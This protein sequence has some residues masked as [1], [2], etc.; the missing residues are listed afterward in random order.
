MPPDP[1]PTKPPRLRASGHASR[2]FPKL[3]EVA[4]ETAA[5]PS[6]RRIRHTSRRLALARRGITFSVRRAFGIDQSLELAAV[7]EDAAALRALVI[8]IPLRSYA[9][10]APPHLGQ[11]IVI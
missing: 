1:V 5:L 11:V 2:L 10:I 8:V 6:L 4:E 9:R 7:E 3:E